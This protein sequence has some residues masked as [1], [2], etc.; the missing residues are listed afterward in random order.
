MCGGLW[1]PPWEEATASRRKFKTQGW[2]GLEMGVGVIAK[3]SR[4]AS[5][6]RKLNTGLQGV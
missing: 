4:A 2:S 3:N 1:E 5:S 6:Q